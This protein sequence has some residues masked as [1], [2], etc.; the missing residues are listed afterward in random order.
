MLK[1]EVNIDYPEYEDE[2]LITNEVLLPSINAL[3]ED[4]DIVLLKSEVSKV[5][6]NG[7]ETAKSKIAENKILIETKNVQIKSV[8]D[9]ITAKN[10]ELEKITLEASGL[11]QSANEFI[12]KRNEL[13]KLLDDSKN[14]DLEIQ[15]QKAPMEAELNSFKKELS[16]TEED[17]VHFDELKLETS[18]FFKLKHL[19]NIDSKVKAF[20]V[21]KWNKFTSFKF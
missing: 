4:I 16:Q 20:L 17:L 3:L 10:T 19:L 8:E 2:E 6:K 21:L 11:S 7:I 1:I 9:E 5:I 12:L 18:K 13:R 15:K 14:E